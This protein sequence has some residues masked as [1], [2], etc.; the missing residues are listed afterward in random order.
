MGPSSS[1]FANY[2]WSQDYLFWKF[3]VIT[4]SWRL[5]QQRMELLI[6]LKS[7]GVGS[8]NTI[9]SWDLSLPSSCSKS[10]GDTEKCRKGTFMG[11]TT[12]WALTTFITWMHSRLIFNHIDFRSAWVRE[13]WLSCFK[14]IIIIIKTKP[15]S[16]RNNGGA[17]KRENT[18]L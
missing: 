13:K 15:R 6:P 10:L 11:K 5:P 8:L 2:L 17:L 9:R 4:N 18:H 3:T 14:I 16:C 12:E 7:L 1:G